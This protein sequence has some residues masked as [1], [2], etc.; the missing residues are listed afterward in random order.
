VDQGI[1]GALEVLGALISGS[2]A[3]SLTP[4]TWCGEV[5][6]LCEGDVETPFFSWRSFL[7]ETTSR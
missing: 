4:P 5:R 2:S 1:Q 7:V 3:K 6:T